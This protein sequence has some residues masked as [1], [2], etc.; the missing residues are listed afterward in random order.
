LRR[1]REKR[2]GN[3][4]ESAFNVSQA[5]ALRRRCWA[6][7]LPADG[8]AHKRTPGPISAFKVEMLKHLRRM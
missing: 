6:L 8:L 1:I 7:E 2:S 4:S 5:M 3:L